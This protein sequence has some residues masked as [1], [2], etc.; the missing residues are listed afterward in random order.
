[1]NKLYREAD[2]GGYWTDPAGVRV[3]LVPVEPVAETTA[4]NTATIS[5]EHW[6]IPEMW[7]S[8]PGKYIVVK[9]EDE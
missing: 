1:M 3:V 9:V 6:H 4:T 2:Y 5:G 8:G 7:V